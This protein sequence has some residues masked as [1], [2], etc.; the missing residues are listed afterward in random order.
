MH[1]LCA[2][3]SLPPFVRPLS[4]HNGQWQKLAI[5]CGRVISTSA[6]LPG[7]HCH[8]IQ[9]S[10]YP[11]VDPL[12]Q[13]HVYTLSL[14]FLSPVSPLFSF[15]TLEQAAK[16]F[17]AAQ[18]SLSI[19]MSGHLFF[20]TVWITR[21]IAWYSGYWK[22]MFLPCC[23]SRSSLHGA[24]VPKGSSQSLFRSPVRYPLCHGAT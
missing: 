19:L 4:Q 23:L 12:M 13:I 7:G 11:R 9:R 6:V 2:T 17:A 10:L 1:K 8:V 14:A 3:M 22:K 20:H 16:P 21:L 5:L 24:V 18:D 15:Q